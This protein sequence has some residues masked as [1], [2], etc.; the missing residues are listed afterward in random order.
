MILFSFFVLLMIFKALTGWLLPPELDAA[1]W[2]FMQEYHIYPA[3]LIA[4]AIQQAGEGIES[5]IKQ[6][7]EKY[8]NANK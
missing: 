1:L 8:D 7:T 5:K 6:L 2:T 3:L 4:I